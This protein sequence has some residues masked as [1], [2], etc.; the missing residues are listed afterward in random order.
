MRVDEIARLIGGE[1]VGDGGREIARASKIEEAGPGDISFIAN[2]K[3]LRYVASTGA[4][5]LIVD[6][7]FH[8]TRTDVSYIRSDDPYR[9]FLKVL[10]LFAP[11]SEHVA[12]GVHATAIVAGDATLGDDVSIGAYAVIGPRCAVGSGSTIHAHATLGADVKLGE[13]VTI[14]PN[15]TLY[16]GT[17]I[18]ANSIIHAGAVIGADGFGFLPTPSGEWEKIPQT[19]IVV[20][21]ENVEIGANA[22]IDRATL[23]ETRIGRGVKIDNLV[24]IAHNVVIGANTAIAA[25]A[26]IS[27][28]T[29]IG[30]ANMIAGQAGIVGHIETAPNV[31]IEAQSGVS[32]SIRKSGRYFGHPAKDHSQA[33]RQEGALRQLPDLLVTIR[34]MRDR[35]RQLEALAGL[36]S[37]EELEESEGRMEDRGS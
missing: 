8:I 3:Y 23:G 2:P 21:E 10:A 5:A 26:G 30:E 13:R 29:R 11:T 20:I 37:E 6:N 19:G 27:G 15:V 25:Q 32:K 33:L 9:A 1:V 31:I 12:R 14:Y 4:A 36:P 16:R 34:R 35:L 24:H 28:S 17:E 22:T 18:G 7:E